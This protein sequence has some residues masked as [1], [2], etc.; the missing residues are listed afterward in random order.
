MRHIILA[1]IA[2]TAFTLNAG[3]QTDTIVLPEPSTLSLQQL[4]VEAMMNSPE[5]KEASEE[6]GLQVAMTRALGTL[7]PPE[8]RYMEENMQG[9]N[10]NTSMFRRLELMQEIPFPTKLFGEK[11]VA[12]I[13]ASH[14][15][16]DRLERIN[17]VLMRLRTAYI[18]LWYVQQT[19]ALQKESL[20][21]LQ[22][23]YSAVLSR[24]RLGKAT[25]QDVLNI[26]LELASLQN[27]TVTTRQ[28]E[29]SAK[30]MIMSILNRQPADTL[31]FAA[32]P[33]EIA[34]PL[35]LDTLLSWAH[36]YRPMVLHDS[37]AIVEGRVEESNAKK[38]Y[39]PD[40]SVA[41]QRVTSPE[42]GFNG[43]SASV[44][45]TLPF[46]PWSLGRTHASTEEAEA[47]TRTAEASY[48]ATLS[49]VDGNIR[50]YFATA[51]AAYQ[52]VVNFQ[53]T[54]L[55]RADRL[56]AT[57]LNEYRL[58]SIDFVSLLNSFRMSVD[59]M[60]DFYMSRMQFENA[61]IQ[62]EHETGM[63]FS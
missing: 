54:I 31:G 3:A 38:D 43:W 8:L 39:L 18:E 56:I 10:I 6:S 2:C 12:G 20:R 58:G 26:E 19:A 16:H 27:Q 36:R 42:S 35:S 60:K 15:D 14:A 53:T 45:V 47:R 51:S 52:Q 17:D 22:N 29:L 41:I 1:V 28:E 48:R 46:A 9:F 62:L 40:F 61:I 37:L 23:I 13:R 5:I 59:L 34:F 33:E 21:E 63:Q 4:E 11:E 50:R 32:I 25:Q 44:G 57:G 30:A 7:P 49:M 24:L 55:P